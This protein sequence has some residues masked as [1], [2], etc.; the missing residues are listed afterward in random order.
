M[1]ARLGAD[2]R[3]PAARLARRGAAG[4]RGGARPPE[5]L[6]FEVTQQQV[7]KALR[8]AAKAL[9]IDESLPGLHPYMLRHGGA[10][11]DFG[12][13]ARP[14]VDVQRR[15]RWQ[16]WHSVRRYEKGA[17]LSQVLQMAPDA[18]QDRAA[19]CADSLGEIVSGRRCPCTPP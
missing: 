5:P 7:S 1:T 13:K 4:A 16:S 9:K 17:R 6:L 11:H 14:I 2:W 10:S 12:S 18:V 19:R 8:D 15:G 3:R